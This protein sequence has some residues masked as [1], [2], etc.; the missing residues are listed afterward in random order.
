MKKGTYIL[1]I[2]L[3][4]DSNIK[5]G[6]LGNIEFKKGY[7]TYIGSAFGPGG[8]KRIERHKN[9]SNGGNKNIRWHID[10]L[11][12]HPDTEVVEIKKFPEK[13]IEC[14]LA[15]ELKGKSIAKFGSSDC[16]CG[17]HLKYFKD[18][19]KLSNIIN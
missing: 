11:N 4:K 8:F 2:K 13:K 15:E 18:K 17:S 16:K 7:Y 5:I 6:A 12:S 9:V 19:I 3:N 10:Y 14:K 1:L